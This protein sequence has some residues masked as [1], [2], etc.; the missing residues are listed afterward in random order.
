[1]KISVIIPVLNEEGY[2]SQTLLC[3]QAMRQRGHEVIVIDGG[4]QDNTVNVATPLSD[5]VIR[6]EKGRAQQMQE[7]VAQ[8]DGDALWFLHAD[9]VTPDNADDIIKQALNKKYWGRFDIVITS[10]HK[11]LRLVGIMMNL[12]SCITGICTGDQG[13]FVKK[14]TYNSIGGLSQIPLMEDIALSKNLKKI[15]RPA[16]IQEVIYTSGR[17][18]ETY[19]I[20]RTILLM[21]TLR[22]LYFLGASPVFLKSKYK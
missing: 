13:I 14:E 12:R 17:R 15:G 7:G 18:W 9:T 10:K 8:S 22:T 21:W 5:M 16:C 19:G 6:S 11:L 3:L 1:M 4:S 2:I 20:I